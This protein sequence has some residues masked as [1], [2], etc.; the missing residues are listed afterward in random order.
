MNLSGKASLVF[1][2]LVACACVAGSRPSSPEPSW[3]RRATAIYLDLRESVWMRWPAAGREN[4]TFCVSCH[5]TM[6]YALARPPLRDALTKASP[7]AEEGS[8]IADVTKRVHL[9]NDVAPY[10][11][12]QPNRS[13]GTEAVLNA[14]ILSS[15][16]ARSGKLSAD[17]LSAFAEMWNLEE[18]QGEL[19]GAWQWIEFGN[20]PWEAYD[21]AYYGAC[22]AAVA[23]GLAPQNYRSTPEIQPNLELLRAYLERE[24]AVVTPINRVMLLWASVKLPGI[25]DRGQ[26]EAII[27]E[28]ISKQRP[29]GGWSLSSLVGTWKRQDGTPLVERSDGFATG[30]I[31]YVLELAAVPSVDVHL[32][33]GLSWLDRNQAWWGGWEGYS[34]NRRRWDLF[35][36]TYYFMDD[37]A[38]AYAT[39]AL[40]QAELTGASIQASR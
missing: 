5:T 24:S 19:R 25:L 21:S 9:W 38:T 6:P 35:S 3:N 31:S 4:G 16:A 11:T 28:V 40:T 30:L 32:K 15:Y 14:L 10:Y 13:R 7:S 34:L 22:L 18:R 2:C 36:N 12:R 26:Q 29:D 17:T 23:V 1:A 20:E 33:E 27:K 8:L 37:A 39:L